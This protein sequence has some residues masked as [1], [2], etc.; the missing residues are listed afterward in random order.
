MNEEEEKKSTKVFMFTIIL[1]LVLK[2]LR[3]C[4]MGLG[5]W[6]FYQN[7]NNKSVDQ[8]KTEMIKNIVFYHHSTL[9]MWFGTNGMQRVST[10][11]R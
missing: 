10:K 9:V 2:V 6:L 8:V 11:Y 5:Y 1:S 4:S 3:T 7:L